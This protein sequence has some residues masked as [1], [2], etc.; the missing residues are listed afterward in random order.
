MRGVAPYLLVAVAA[1]LLLAW[2]RPGLGVVAAVIVLLF[3]PG[4]WWRWRIRRFRRGVKALRAGERERAREDFEAF[5][6]DIDG[7]DRFER[8]QPAF[9]LGTRYSYRGAALSNLGVVELEDGRPARALA[10]FQAALKEDP[11]ALQ[12]LYG[13]A[14]ALRV[15]GELEE[16]ERF[17]AAALELRPRYVAARLLLALIRRERA[18]RTGAEEAL[19]PLREEGEDPEPALEKLREH[20]TRKGAG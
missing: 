11:R 6:D 19:A 14:A 8:L 10:R 9:N 7:D 16:A 18:D 4:R 3:L 5:L 2:L 15:L 20:W 17:A 12:A 13:K 1:V